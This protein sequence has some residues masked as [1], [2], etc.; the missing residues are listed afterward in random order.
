MGNRLIEFIYLEPVTE[1]EIN[2]LIKALKDTATGFDNMNSMSLKIHC[3][4]WN[5]DQ[6]TD[7][8][9]Q[10]VSYPRNFP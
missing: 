6:A 8:Y 3:I 2:A 5:S 7:P 4:F 10:F 1:N 9:L